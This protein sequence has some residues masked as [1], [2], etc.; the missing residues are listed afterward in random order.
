M[1][2]EDYDDY[3]GVVT[4]DELNKMVD[5]EY[6]SMS[7][8]EKHIRLVQC[9]PTYLQYTLSLASNII[10]SNPEAKF[11]INEYTYKFEVL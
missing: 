2:R 8:T 11:L 1:Y 10:K 5:Q 7:E 6:E 3:D 9:D 4:I